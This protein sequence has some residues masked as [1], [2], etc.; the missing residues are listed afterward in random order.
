MKYLA[1]IVLSLCCLSSFAAEKLFPSIP[2]KLMKATHK[3]TGYN[4]KTGTTGHG[5]CVSVDLTKYGL[6]GSRY[7]LT[8]A[9]CISDDGK[10]REIS[11]DMP[12]GT[13][14]S[15]KMIA[16]DEDA[17]I[18]LV[19]VGADMPV[20]IPIADDSIEV[21]DALITIGSPRATPLT[22]NFGFLADKGSTRQQRHAGWY[23]GSM[24]ITHGNSGG[25]VFDPNKETLVGIITAVVEEF[26]QQAPN[27]ALFIGSVEID[28]F[29]NKNLEKIKKFI[30]KN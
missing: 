8:A 29:I 30:K 22:G 3:I 28:Q 2:K 9:H 26:G 18:A 1:S 25:P 14:T 13:W 24:S 17:D 12:D 5:A 16:M 21:G 10:L 7:V 6:E 19:Y 27:I 20:L 15:G 4:S 23:Q 11:V